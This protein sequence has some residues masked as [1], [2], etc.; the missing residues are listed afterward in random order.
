MEFSVDFLESP[1]GILTKDKIGSLSFI[2][3]IFRFYTGARLQIKDVTK[4]YNN[5]LKNGMPVDIAFSDENVSYTNHMRVLS[6]SRPVKDT[7]PLIDEYDVTLVSSVYFEDTLGTVAHTG[8]VST[9]TEDVCRNRLHIEPS[10]LDILQTDDLVRRR[11]QLGERAQDFLVRLS[12]Y[13]TS[14]RTPVYLY[15]DEKG[16]VNLRSVA[17]MVSVQPVWALCGT[18]VER[19]GVVFDPSIGTLRYR[20]LAL[21][22]DMK[23]ACSGIEEVFTT[24]NFFSASDTAGSLVYNSVETDNNQSA[25]STPRRMGFYG[26]NKAPS[27]AFALAVRDTFES[28]AFTYSASVDLL[29]FQMERLPIGSTA[30]I[31]LPHSPTERSG[32][33][34]DANLGE[35]RYLVT[36][37]VYSYTGGTDYTTSLSLIQ[38]AS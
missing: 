36:Q 19:E 12:K 29:G 7:D 6:F 35:G 1:I 17:D 37:A 5:L 28:T 27:D 23:K 33:G 10:A 8:S 16:M 15:H 30:Y 34:E 38:V 9:I 3:S 25:A 4:T 2:A 32:S 22:N 26:W 24:E 13:G 20:S 31:I 11:Y 14:S 21:A 18:T